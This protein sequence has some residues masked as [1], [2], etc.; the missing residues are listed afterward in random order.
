MPDR[1][2]M[3]VLIETALTTDGGVS[4]DEGL[5]RRILARVAEAGA[6]RPARRRVWLGWALALPVAACLLV[7]IFLPKPKLK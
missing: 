2:E 7:M 5:E 6:S 4:A 3:A 1:D